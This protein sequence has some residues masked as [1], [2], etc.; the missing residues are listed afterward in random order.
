[1]RAGPF[2]TQLQVAADH[3][4]FAGH[5]PGAPVLPGVLLAAWVFEALAGAPDLSRS[6]G[7]CPQIDELKFLAPVGPRTSLRIALSSS[8]NAV[9]FQVWRGTTVVARGRLSAGKPA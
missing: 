6:L 1:M 8:G 4:A 7:A 5:F 9:S 3:P 2:E